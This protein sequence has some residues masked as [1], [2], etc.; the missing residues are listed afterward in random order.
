MVLPRGP[1]AVNGPP[2]L[3]LSAD[4][5]VCR[6]LPISV[7]RFARPAPLL[8]LDYPAIDAMTILTPAVD[9]LIDLAL[10]EDLGRGNVTTSAVLDPSVEGRAELVAREPM[11][12]AGLEV[13]V[14]VFERVDPTVT[15]TVAIGDGR[16]AEAGATIGAVQGRAAG[17]LAGER[18]ALNFLQRLSGVATL[19]R[20][21]VQAAGGSGLRITDTRK[22]TPGF[23]HLEKQAVRAGGGAN[24]RYDLGSG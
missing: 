19:T 13:A 17:V 23:R 2:G 7:G 16:P 12:V 8:P 1:W 9:R 20:A 14:A 10:E 3:W 21:F 5:P 11:V 4:R 22:T 24:H 15:V 6:I 18:T